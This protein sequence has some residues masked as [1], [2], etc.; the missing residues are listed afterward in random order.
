MITMIVTIIYEIVVDKKGALDVPEKLDN[1]Y[2]KVW[3]FWDR[4]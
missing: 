2:Y 4:F 1:L 3:K